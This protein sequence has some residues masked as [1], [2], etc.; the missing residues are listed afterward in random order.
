[1][2]IRNR[3]AAPDER[4]LRTYPSQ[5]GLIHLCGLLLV[6]ETRHWDRKTAVVAEQRRDV[7]TALDKVVSRIEIEDRC[8]RHLFDLPVHNEAD[9]ERKKRQ[10]PNKV[11]VVQ[12][13]IHNSI[14]GIMQL[15][16]ALRLEVIE[17]SA[18]ENWF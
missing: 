8:Q 15:A 17:L 1:M 18:I 3:V 10:E 14:V 11:C 7:H 13:H 5:E 12:Q 2:L 6:K 4:H 16:L 9:H